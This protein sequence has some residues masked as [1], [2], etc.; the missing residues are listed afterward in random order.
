MD[1]SNKIVERYAVVKV[2]KPN[3]KKAAG[4]GVTCSLFGQQQSLAIPPQYRAVSAGGERQAR[5]T[6]FR[7]IA[8][9]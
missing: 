3:T 9:G 8:A 7:F 2:S 4:N 6:P 1:N 5:F